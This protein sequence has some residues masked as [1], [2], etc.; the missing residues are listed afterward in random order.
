VRKPPPD[1]LQKRRPPMHS[2]CLWKRL[3]KT[4]LFKNEEQISNSDMVVIKFG[5]IK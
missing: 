4:K 2:P 1:L 5:F 3:P